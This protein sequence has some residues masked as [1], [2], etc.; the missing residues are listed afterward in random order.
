MTD[1]APAEF[2]PVSAG[3]DPADRVDTAIVNTCRAVFARH[4]L[5]PPM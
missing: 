4:G 3:I 2:I 5:H 1:G